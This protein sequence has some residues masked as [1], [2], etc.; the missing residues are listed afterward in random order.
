MIRPGAPPGGRSGVVER[1][2]TFAYPV[3]LAL[4]DPVA[5]HHAKGKRS[6]PTADERERPRAIRLASDYPGADPSAAA[7]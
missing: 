4:S 6:R 1:P 2:P 3:A 5:I 7:G